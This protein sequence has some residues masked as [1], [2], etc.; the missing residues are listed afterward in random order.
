MAT[1]SLTTATARPQAYLAAGFMLLA[2]FFA[3]NMKA[4]A[5]ESRPGRATA[6]TDDPARIFHD[7]CSVCHGEKGDGN[8]MARY[9]LDPPPKNFTV[10]KTRKE[11]SRIHMIEVLNKGA[12]TKEGKLTAMTAWSSQLSARHIEAVVDYII[13]T[14]M[15]GK[16]M[17]DGQL[18]AEGLEHQGHD[19]SSANVKPREYPYGLKPSAAHGKSIYAANCARCHGEKGDGRG[20]AA[21]T[22]PDKPRNFR[23]ADFQEFAS[24]F[25]LFSAVSRGK[26]HMPA[27]EK[28]LSKQDTA[29]VAEYVLRTFVKARRAAPKAK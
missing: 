9:V 12:R 23:D 25:S 21:L 22:V 10:E 3:M 11:L 26:G 5:A 14:F 16:V 13:V 19:H 6:N 20:N 1:T 24:G 17:P 7:Y 2:A 27:W 18:R 4:M 15:D 8:S 29:D 28:T